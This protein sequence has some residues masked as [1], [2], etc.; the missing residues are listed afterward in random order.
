[1][2]LEQSTYRESLRVPVS[3]WIIAAAAVVTLFA[4]VAVP[5][6]TIA[7]AVVG[8]LAA[9]LLLALFLRYGGARVEVDDTRLHAGR[10]EIDRAYLGTVEAL[11]GDDA[12]RAFGRDCDPKAFL[13]L[14]SYISG[15]VRV[16]IT[17][18]AD[19]APY[20]LIATRH[21]DRL[22]AALSGHSVGRS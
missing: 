10:A 21:P 16:Q 19:P 11:T 17:D 20:W 3:W 6:G 2:G 15:A 12:R 18:P 5:A 4:I 13:V 7:G 1:M 9:I 8:G 14:R 22:A